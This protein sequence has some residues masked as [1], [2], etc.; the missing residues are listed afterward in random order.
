M[1]AAG[2]TGGATGD[3]TGGAIGVEN[4]GGTMDITGLSCCQAR[5][6][7]WNASNCQ[8]L[9]LCL[10]IF[11]LIFSQIPFCQVIQD[12]HSMNFCQVKFLHITLVSS[13][14]DPIVKPSSHT[15]AGRA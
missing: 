3:A 4:A 7:Q 15:K 10:S 1:D 6:Q 12:Q 9:C 2:A 13:D 14:H 5:K 11:N 8:Q